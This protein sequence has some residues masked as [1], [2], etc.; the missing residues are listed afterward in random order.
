MERELL[1]ALH[2][3]K[4][5]YISGEELA[6]KFR[7]SRTSIWNYIDFLRKQG[8]EIEA[9]PNLGYR[10]LEVPDRLLPD[11]IQYGLDTK[12][13]GRSIY[14]YEELESTNDTAW[15]K[16][17][18]G[19]PEGTVIFA[20][21]QTKGRGRLKRHWYSAK[22]KGLCFSV[23]LR[24]QLTPNYVPM[25]TAMSAVSVAMAVRKLT[26]SSALIKWPNDIFLNG[27]KLGGILT[28]I[29]TEL[30]IIKFVI[31]GIGI[32]VNMDKFPDELKKTATSLKLEDGE[33]YSRI[34]LA[35]EI[36]KSLED[37]YNLLLNKK[38][39]E[40][41]AEW[42]DLSWVLGKRVSVGETEGQALGIDEQGALIVRQD[43][44]INKYITSGD[45]ICC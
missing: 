14:A 30:D 37:Y 9:H 10:L 35:R 8:Y 19:E 24:P 32:N 13:I 28:E 3:Y 39:D 29:N 22:R 26:G 16:A 5:G 18:K 41:I 20:E 21:F 1:Y 4:D 17:I 2:R 15:E 6:E 40:I 34:E 25:I 12:I 11:E 43:D 31:L 44:G 36:L 42:K 45:V 23:I 38:W 33:N 27:K 7:V